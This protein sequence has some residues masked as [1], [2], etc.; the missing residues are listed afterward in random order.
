MGN[1][2]KGFIT[3]VACVG[4]FG[5]VFFCLSS[6]FFS[7][8]PNKNYCEMPGVQMAEYTCHFRTLVKLIH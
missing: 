8:F 6:S 2:L 1:V 5:D 3:L 7:E 4:N